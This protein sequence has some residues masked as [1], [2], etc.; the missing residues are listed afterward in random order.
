MRVGKRWVRGASLVAAVAVSG[1]VLAGDGK[2][3]GD[4]RALSDD[5]CVAQCDEASDK[6]MVS[7]G[8]DTSK[9]KECD[10]T[11]DSCLRKCG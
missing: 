5:K 3:P 9:Q 10:A 6:C 11:Y 8:H 1:A 7:A 4:G 2:P